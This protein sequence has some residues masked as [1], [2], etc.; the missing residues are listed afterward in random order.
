MVTF[1]VPSGKAVSSTEEP[2]LSGKLMLKL[3][4]IYVQSSQVVVEKRREDSAVFNLRLI[5]K[6]KVE[7]RS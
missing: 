4:Y 7:L 6:W 2:T 3:K 1:N 5:S